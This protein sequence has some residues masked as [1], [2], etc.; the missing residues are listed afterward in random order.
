MMR[1]HCPLLT[2]SLFLLAGNAARADDDTPFALH[3]LEVPYRVA[4]ADISD[5]DGDGLGDV[6]WTSL[7]GVPPDER[8]ELR[9][10]FQ[11]RDGGFSEKADWRSPLPEGVAA[12]DLADLDGRPGN[13]IAIAQQ[14][15]KQEVGRVTWRLVKKRDPEKVC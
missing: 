9:V 8:R 13:E 6:L 11:Q 1:G 14:F 4:Q 10:H 5:L 15:E 7:E 12:Y 3:E 2:L